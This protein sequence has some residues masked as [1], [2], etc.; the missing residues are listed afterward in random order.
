MRNKKVH[1][2]IIIIFIIIVGVSLYYIIE[3]PINLGLDLKGGTQIILRPTEAGGGE[4]ISEKLEAAIDIIR[5]RIDSLGGSE[6]LITKD[7]YKN[8]VI[9]LPG[10]KDPERAEEIIGK[11]AEL[12]FRLVTGTFISTKDQ[13]WNLVKFDAEKGELI[14]DPDAE[15]VLLVDDI[16]D[17]INGNP[18]KI[19]GELVDDPESEEKLLVEFTE[20][21]SQE[22]DTDAA[23]TNGTGIDPEKIIGKIIY[24]S[25]TGELLLTDYN[26]DSEIGEILVYS[27]TSA[28]TLVEPALLTGD[29][30]ANAAA[31]YSTNGEISVALSFKDEGVEIFKQITTDNIGR[32]TCDICG[33]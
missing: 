13:T 22:E 16:N 25:G 4:V 14:I 27:T 1:I 33:G 6:P 21:D 7:L 32:E 24:D 8:I 20:E 29:S 11:T 5:D 19:D 26:D 17:F 30:L 31:R 18:Y 3:K 15:E 2:T 10:V 28:A 9:Q 12:E 23:D